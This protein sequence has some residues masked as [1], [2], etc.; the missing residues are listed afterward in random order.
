[1]TCVREMPWAAA[2]RSKVSPLFN[3]A[4]MAARSKCVSDLP[5]IAPLSDKVNVFL[6]SLHEYLILWQTRISVFRISE[7]SL[8]SAVYRLW[9]T[10][11]DDPHL[12]HFGDFL[13]SH[14]S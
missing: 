14:A 6:H 13:A 1:M 9:M 7:R 2:T 8:I 3:S 10:Q 11:A 4:I 5:T 12:G